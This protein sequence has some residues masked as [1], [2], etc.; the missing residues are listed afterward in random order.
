MAW[1][2]KVVKI[3]FVKEISMLQVFV[4]KYFNTY[5]INDRKG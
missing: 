3:I 5:D 2:S 4:Q 1:Y